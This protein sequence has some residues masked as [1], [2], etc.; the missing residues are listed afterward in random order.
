MPADLGY[1]PRGIFMASAF[2]KKDDYEMAFEELTV[3]LPFVKKGSQA[4]TSAAF[5]CA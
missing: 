1:H 3:P 2:S 5:R 4:I